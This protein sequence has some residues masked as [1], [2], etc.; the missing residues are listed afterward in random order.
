[1]SI[2]NMNLFYN[3]NNNPMGQNQSAEI[4]DKTLILSSPSDEIVVSSTTLISTNG[5][6]LFIQKDH[7]SCDVSNNQCNY[8]K[9]ELSNSSLND[10]NQLI[11][12]SL[13]TFISGFYQSPGNPHH[14][15]FNLSYDDVCRI[16]EYSKSNA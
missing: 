7:D 6:D 4:N 9:D 1:M 16:A 11:D 5:D 14:I 12:S 13:F 15:F 2:P 10:V 8:Y 3:S